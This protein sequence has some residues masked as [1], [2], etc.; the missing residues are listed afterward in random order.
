V[1]DIDGGNKVKIATGGESLGTG[2][3]APDNLHLSFA[4]AG[5]RSQAY[6]VGADGSGLRQLPPMGG[7]PFNAVWSPDE[8]SVYVSV[9]ANAGQMHNIWSWKLDSS[10]PEKVVDDC[11]MVEDADPGGQ[12][13]LGVVLSGGKT[14]IYEVSISDRKCI[15]LLPGAVTESGVFA[16]DGKSFLYAVAS[17]GDVTIYR[18]PWRDGKTIGTP[19]VALKVPFAFPLVYGGNAYDFSRDLST[20]VYARP[21]SHADL[22]L[23]SQ[24]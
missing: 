1:A 16:R 19:Q 6:I 20:I 10:N 18:Q 11:G 15:L 23:L 21:S 3:W 7:T 13:L 14:G 12:Y 4:E 9:D 5:A 22:Y 8:K 17:R 24:K 2:L